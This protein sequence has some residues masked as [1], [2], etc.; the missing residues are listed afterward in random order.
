VTTPTLFTPLRAG[1]LSLR[2]RIV[3]SALTR[4]RAGRTHVPNELMAQ[5]YG[6][7][8]SSGLIVTE[9]TMVAADGCAFIGEGGLYDEG[10]TAGWRLVTDAV[11][12]RGGLILVQLWH[13]GRAAHSV[14]N[15]GVQP[16]SAT[17]RAI[18]GSSIRTPEG[19]KDYEV[20]RRLSTEEIPGIIELFRAAAVRSREAA[21][22]GVQ[23][24]GAHGYLLDQFLRD[25]VNDR[26][27]PYGGSVPNRA[28]LLLEVVDAVIAELGA[29]RV[30]VRISPLVPFNDIAD[31]APGELVAH[32][33]TELSRRRIA[34]LELRHNDYREL[35]EQELARIARQRFTGPLFVNG[36]YGRDSAQAA[37]ASGAAD[38]VVF[39]HH[40]VANPDLVERFEKGLP[41]ADLNPA[42]LYSPGPEGYV[43]YPAAQV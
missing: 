19:P 22:D 26:T 23:I 41:P 10:T 7:R 9:A 33:A 25:S 43:D 39:G 32:V 8:A 12:R 21:F 30:S 4:C 1:D 15:G 11:H 6:Q 40:Y 36:G 18:R 35:K 20:P 27:D 17:S 5:Y 3:M 42:T 31:S 13:P 2:N 38:A 28:R 29:S 14:L 37:I 24:H 16:I 34:F